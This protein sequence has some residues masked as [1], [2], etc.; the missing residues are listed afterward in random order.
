M[1]LR[2]KE[3]IF[4]L[5][6]SVDHIMLVKVTEGFHQLSGIDLNSLLVKSFLSAQMGEQFSS[7][8]EVNDE[9]EFCFGLE[10]KVEAY[11]VGT[12]DLFKNVSL[13]LGFLE[14]I[15]LNQLVLFQNFHGVGVPRV[16]LLYEVDL[17]EAASPN[18]LDVV[19]VIGADLD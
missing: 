10:R 18:N 17:A 12:L 9:V 19:E 7:I 5:E 2:I 15:L 1:A 11:D 14:E 6:I 4:G 3:N 13:G 8:E 16:L